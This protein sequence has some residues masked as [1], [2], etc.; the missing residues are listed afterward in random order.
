MPFAAAY[1]AALLL[2]ENK[3]KRVM[4]YAIPAI[5]FTLNFFLRAAFSLEAVA[6][7][8]VAVLLY[9]A[10]KHSRS[11]SETAAWM[12]SFVVVMIL[13][14]ALLL[15]FE[16]TG[17]FSSLALR[18][19]YSNIYLNLKNIVIKNLLSLTSVTD[20]G[21]TVFSYNEYNANSMFNE[22]ILSERQ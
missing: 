22:L 2:Y 19:F 18:Q 4:S 12:I 8:V 11:K 10:V 7:V 13:L 5:M 15:A 3:G 20:E 16:M 9:F 1:Y 14:S 17:N 6:Y 21:L